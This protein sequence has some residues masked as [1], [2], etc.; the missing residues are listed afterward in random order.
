[1]YNVHVVMLYNIVVAQCF[2]ILFDFVAFVF[3]L[4]LW[5]SLHISS[6]ANVV[7]KNRHVYVGHIASHSHMCMYMY[8]YM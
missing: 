6:Y 2:I 5:S 7:I 4:F 8:M 3:N 1:M